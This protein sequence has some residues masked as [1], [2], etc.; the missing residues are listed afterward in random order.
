MKVIP[1]VDNSEHL[2]ANTRKAQEA[3]DVLRMVSLEE[4]RCRCGKLL[5]KG[6]FLAGEIE[7]KCK[8]CGKISLLLLP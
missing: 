1:V 5:F 7:I 3:R 4:Y 6:H 2:H 8:R